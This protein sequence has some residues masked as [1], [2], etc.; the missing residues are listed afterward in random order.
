MSEP[1]WVGSDVADV[2]DY[3]TGMGKFRTMLAE[4]RDEALTERVVRTM[5]EQFAA[6]QRDDGVWVGTASWL[7]SARRP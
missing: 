2:I 5:E 6:R 1:A 3:F 4:L 7:V